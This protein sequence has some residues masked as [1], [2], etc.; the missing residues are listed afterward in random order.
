ML[1]PTL[2]GTV[3]AREARWAVLAFVLAVLAGLG[4]CVWLE[5]R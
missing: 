2:S 4:A 5:G 1:R 3:A